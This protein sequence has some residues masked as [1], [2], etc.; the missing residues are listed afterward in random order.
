[1]VIADGVAEVAS[2]VAIHEED[3]DEGDVVELET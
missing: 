1:V 2:G 3:D